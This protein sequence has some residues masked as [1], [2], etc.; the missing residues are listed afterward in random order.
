MVRKKRGGEER[1]GAKPRCTNNCREVGESPQRQERHIR[2]FTERSVVR[3]VAIKDW[4]TS[5]D[6]EPDPGIAPTREQLMVMK[7]NG[8]RA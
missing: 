5:S 6:K 7:V 3:H 4:Q 2:W 1:Y 8:L